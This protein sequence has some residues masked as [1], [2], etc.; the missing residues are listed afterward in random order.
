MN[1]KYIKPIIV[2]VMVEELMGDHTGVLQTSPIVS[3]TEPGRGGILM[4]TMNLLLR[5]LFLAMIIIIK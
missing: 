4:M 1:K 3:A 5:S 2:N